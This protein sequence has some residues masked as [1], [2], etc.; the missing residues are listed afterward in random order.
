MSQEGTPSFRQQCWCFVPLCLALRWVSWH[1]HLLSTAVS[2]QPCIACSAAS[3]HGLFYQVVEQITK[4]TW[5][6]GF[7]LIRISILK[8]ADSQANQKGLCGDRGE[9]VK[10]WLLKIVL[11]VKN[12]QLS[13]GL[14][15]ESLH[16]IHCGPS[17]D[18]CFLAL[19]SVSKRLLSALSALPFI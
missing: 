1:S 8:S 3:A 6:G 5:S 4:L 17:F 19:L 13:K 14:I 15:V 18:L 16:V 9:H 2:S 10:Q 11:L 7:V 12:C